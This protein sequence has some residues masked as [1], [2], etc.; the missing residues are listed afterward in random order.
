MSSRGGCRSRQ[1]ILALTLGSSSILVPMAVAPAQTG[2]PGHRP[3]VPH[4]LATFGNTDSLD[5]FA[6]APNARLYLARTRDGVQIVHAGSGRRVSLA[7]AT[8]DYFT[9]SSLSNR[10][11]WTHGSSSNQLHVWTAPVDP[12]SGA[13]QSAPQRVSLE[14]A[15]GAP[16]VSRTGAWLAYLR[17]RRNI[18]GDTSELVV[19][20]ARGGPER[21]LARFQ[22]LEAMEWGRDDGSLY[23]QNGIGTVQQIRIDSKQQRT[24]RIRPELSFANMTSDRTRLLL[25]PRRGVVREGDVGVV[26]D[27][28]GREI[29]TFPLP[30]G[31]PMRYEGVLGDS[32]IVWYERSER[33]A[34]R[35]LTLADGSSRTLGE[36]GDN[37]FAPQWSP[38][39]RHIAFLTRD[40]SSIRVGTVRTDGTQYRLYTQIDAEGSLL[41][42]AWSPNGK[43]LVARSADRR[44]LFLV[45]VSSGTAREVFRHER[46]FGMWRWASDGQS[47]LLVERAAPDQPGSIRKVMLNGASH[48]SGTVPSFSGKGIQL[49][50]WASDTSILLDGQGRVSLLNTA[51]GSQ[52]VLHVVDSAFSVWG[53]ATTHDGSRVATA[54]RGES[55]NGKLYVSSGTGGSTREISLP[56]WLLGSNLPAFS[57]DGRN[58]YTIGRKFADPLGAHLYQVPLDGSASRRLASLGG[59]SGSFSLSPDD[60]QLVYS[61]AI[62]RSG[63]FIVV[64]LPQSGMDRSSPARR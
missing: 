60:R 16:A 49:M 63:K 31:S 50:K 57:K 48:A 46:P 5:G 64:P 53:W 45:D 4:V 27:T 14:P 19:M 9:W 28:L 2:A 41:A 23:V 8:S 55:Q 59:S 40:G 32:A 17:S 33:S 10:V 42:I 25:V 52:K 62:G 44:S 24:I 47:I 35:L 3:S 15:I 20:P 36:V 51:S 30:V 58:V 43:Q 38:D 26:C 13:L 21:V 12:H 6:V 7:P 22:S 37:V 34:L 61:T 18:T 11:V 1:Q 29:G 39:G 54:A 56:F